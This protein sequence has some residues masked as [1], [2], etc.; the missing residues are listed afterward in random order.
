MQPAGV[1]HPD[2]GL[3]GDPFLDSSARLWL[4]IADND[5]TAWRQIQVA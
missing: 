2:T 4:S 1:T 5:A 3:K